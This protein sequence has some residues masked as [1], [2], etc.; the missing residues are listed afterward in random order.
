MYAKGGISYIYLCYGI[1]HLF[2]IVTNKKDI[3]HAVLIRGIH[4]VDGVEIIKKRRKSALNLDKLAI[5]PGTAAQALGLTVAKNGISLMSKE[6]WIENG[7]EAG[8]PFKIKKG[9]R[10][11]VD[12][13]GKDALLP[14]RFYIEKGQKS[15]Q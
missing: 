4:P 3:P 11:G 7:H 2:N 1:H 12:Y 6:I 8:K 15:T 5:G 9:P 14:Y 10:I 13:A